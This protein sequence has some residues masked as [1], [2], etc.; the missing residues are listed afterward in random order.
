[1]CCGSVDVFCD[2]VVMW[3]MFDDVL[4]MVCGGGV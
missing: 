3:L 1:M 2:D 4:V